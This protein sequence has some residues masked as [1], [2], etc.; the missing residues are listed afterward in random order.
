MYVTFWEKGQ[1]VQELMLL[2]QFLPSPLVK[3][4]SKGAK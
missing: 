4:A 3:L 2:V 1:A